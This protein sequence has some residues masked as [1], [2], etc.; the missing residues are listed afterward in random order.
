MKMASK[1]TTLAAILFGF[2]LTPAMAQSQECVL[3]ISTCK[4]EHTYTVLQNQMAHYYGCKNGCNECMK[5]CDPRIGTSCNKLLQECN[6]KLNG[7]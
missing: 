2:M 1:K 3:A 4:N 7:K 5:Y 6:N